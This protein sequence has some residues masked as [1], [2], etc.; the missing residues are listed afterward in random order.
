LAPGTGG[1]DVL[2]L[3]RVILKNRLTDLLRSSAHKTTVSLDS[4]GF[5]RRQEPRVEPEFEKRIELQSVIEKMKARLTDEIEK[6]YLDAVLEGARTRKELA[7][8]LGIAL[9]EVDNLQRRLK[10]KAELA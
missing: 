3:G 10:Y 5:D 8:H 4:E 7:V 9:E 6:K 2:P 1:E